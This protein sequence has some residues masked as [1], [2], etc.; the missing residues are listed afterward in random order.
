MDY[1]GP[2][3]MFEHCL[4]ELKGWPD[5]SALDFDA[6]L[7]HNVTVDPSTAG[8]ASTS[9]RTASSSWAS[10]PTDMGI[11]LLQGSHE[12]DVSEPWRQ[13]LVPPS[14]RPARCRAWSPPAPSSWRRP[15][16]DPLVVGG[17]A[18]ITPGMQ[19]TSPTEAQ[20]TTGTDKTSAGKLFAKATWPGGGGAA[21]TGSHR[22]DLRGCQPRQPHQPPPRASRVVLAGL[23]PHG[24][25]DQPSDRQSW[26]PPPSWRRPTWQ[27]APS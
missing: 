19:M 21:I 26:N 16:I 8:A 9:T 12:L 23:S 13:Q 18:A 11:F 6:F 25:I 10:G 15:S 7:S 17:T 22:L 24:L 1:T 5:E 3:L 27:P 2:I 20:I 4:D 14:R